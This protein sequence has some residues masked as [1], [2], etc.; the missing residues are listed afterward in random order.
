MT[1]FELFLFFLR[2]SCVTFGG[3]IVILGMAELELSQRDDISEEELT[4]MVSLA[5]S[6]PGPIAVSISWLVGRYYRGLKGSLA[7]L[8]GMIIPPFLIILFVSPVVL[9]YS[10]YPPVMGFFR[11]VLAGTAGIITC[12]VFKNVKN[13]VWGKWWN[14]LPYL[15]VIGMIGG[16]GVHPLIAIAVT[17]AVLM[18]KERFVTC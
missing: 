12:T 18:L 15:M 14:L 17:L 3:G 6:I 13:A 2:I 10:E 4:D 16:F 9:R 5:A 1:A 8:C 7:A 11:G